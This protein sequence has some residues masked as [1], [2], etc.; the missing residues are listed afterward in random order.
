MDH[1]D[2][3]R[4]EITHDPLDLTLHKILTGARNGETRVM[5]PPA[6]G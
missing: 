6:A 2:R 1:A 3:W 4:A 5:I